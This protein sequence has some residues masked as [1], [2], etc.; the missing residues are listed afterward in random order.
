MS[1]SSESYQK[2][3]T[4]INLPLI[5]SGHSVKRPNEVL[6]TVIKSLYLD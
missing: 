6:Q 1:A 2:K 4:I 3:H 5:N